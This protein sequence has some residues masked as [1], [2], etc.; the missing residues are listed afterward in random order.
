MTVH[1][2]LSEREEMGDSDGQ[3]KNEAKAEQPLGSDQVDWQTSTPSYFFK[4]SSYKE[5]L[6]L[7][8]K[9][10]KTVNQIK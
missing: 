10:H 2:L 6:L 5:T 1:T 3:A 7:Q 4:K 8:K 9:K